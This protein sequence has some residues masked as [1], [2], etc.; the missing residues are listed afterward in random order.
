MQYAFRPSAVQDLPIDDSIPARA[1]SSK[2]ALLTGL[3]VGV[4]TVFGIVGVL[5][6]R[7]KIQ[8]EDFAASLTIDAGAPDAPKK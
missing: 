1:M 8:E 3:L 5:A 6:W 4:T 7:A 2:T